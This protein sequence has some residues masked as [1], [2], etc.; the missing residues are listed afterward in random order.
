MYKYVNILVKAHM[1]NKYIKCKV[2]IKWY[3]NASSIQ[4]CPDVARPPLWAM[5]QHFYSAFV[6]NIKLETVL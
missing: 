4:V 2:V 3:S 6:D 1:K 5:L